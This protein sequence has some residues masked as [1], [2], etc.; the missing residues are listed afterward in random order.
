M[1]DVVGAP[2]LD[3]QGRLAALITEPVAE[4]ADDEETGVYYA[5][6]MEALRDALAGREPA[7][8]GKKPARLK[9]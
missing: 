7:I 6:G 9:R 5:F 3:A 1:R 4:A 8:V 2:V